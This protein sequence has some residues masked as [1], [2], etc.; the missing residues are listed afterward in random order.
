[1]SRAAR[2]RVDL[3]ALR[4]NLGRV[5]QCA[6]TS[7]VAAVIKA[8]GYGHGQVQVARVLADADALAVACIEEALVLREAGIDKPIL[9]LEGVF[10]ATELPL[11]HRWNLAIVVHDPGQVE[12]LEHARLEK[13]LSVWLKID[14]GMHRLGVAPEQVAAI[15][16]RLRDCP[17]VASIKLLSH[18]ARADERE[19]DFTWRQ[20]QVFEELSG[21]LPGERSLANSAAVLAWPQT[22]FDWVRP[23]LMLYGASPFANTLADEEGLQPVMTLM[24]RLISVRRLAKGEAVGYGGTWV[25]PEAMDIGVAAIGYADGYPRHAPSGTPVLVNGRRAGLAGRVS[26]DMLGIDL[27]GHPEAKVGDPVVLWGPDLPV[28]IIAKAAGT[29]PYTLFCGVT[30]RVHFQYDER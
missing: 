12:M 6:P 15:W 14:T 5:R 13:P 24:T 25:C 19:V 10:E 30:A 29:I 18:L 26:M 7:R 4:H 28:E 16:R 11:C 20:L 3:K 27:R 22:H 9:L 23:G 8:N 1:M 2:A 17:T 21:T